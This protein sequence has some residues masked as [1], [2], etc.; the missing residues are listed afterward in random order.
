MK[1]MVTGGSGFL[2][3][4][5]ADEL[6]RRGHE[7]VIFDRVA[8]PHLG[9][10]QAMVVG[11]IRD[12]GA[13]RAAVAGCGA[14]YNFAAW[15]EIGEGD[16]VEVAEV[17][18]LGNLNVLEACREHRVGRYLFASTIY[19]YSDKGSF[20]RASKQAAELFVEEYQRQYGLPYTILRYGSLYGPRANAFNWVRAMLTQALTAGKIVRQGDGEEIRE[21]IHVLD[22]AASSVRALEAEFANQRLLLTGSTPIKIRDLLT[23]V[24]EM[25]G[26]RVAIE[27]TSEPDCAHYEITPYC[28]RPQPARKLVANPHVDLGQGLLECL[29]E[30][31]AER[32]RKENH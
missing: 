3:S 8:S 25:M 7:V 12:R 27:Y 13:V 17:N 11:D 1:I 30:L 32:D 9:A 24:R 22:A 14:V 20:Y 29:Y 19:V 26:D 18:I 15:A 2:G 28:F 21:Y 4:H 10:G 16:P 6:V 31:Q 5:V 23:M